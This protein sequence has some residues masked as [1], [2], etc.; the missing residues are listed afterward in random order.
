MARGGGSPKSSRKSIQSANLNISPLVL[1]S[2]VVVQQTV[3]QPQ[4]T[5]VQENLD[6]VSEIALLAEQEF[7]ALV[8]SQLALIQEV[9]TIKNNIRVNHFLARFSQVVSCVS[10]LLRAVL[11]AQADQ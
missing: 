3:V 6:L 8:Q 10:A 2:T 9:E 7:S 4:V 1:G 5:I 11:F